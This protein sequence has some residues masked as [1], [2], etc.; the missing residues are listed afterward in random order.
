MKRWVR[1]HR[2]ALSTAVARLVAQPFSSLSNLLVMTLTLAV[3]LIG[4][5]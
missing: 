5:A 3:P 4:W 1:Q 2:Y